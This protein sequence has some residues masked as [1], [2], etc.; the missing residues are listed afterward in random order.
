MADTPGEEPLAGVEQA[1]ERRNV[2][3]ESADR[4][5]HPKTRQQLRTLEPGQPAGRIETGHIRIESS[6]QNDPGA[7]NRDPERTSAPGSG[8]RSTS[9]PTALASI[10]MFSGVRQPPVVA[11]RRR[12]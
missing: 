4:R 2:A 6:M 3:A 11:S 1:F 7:I 9:R 10:A 5:H 12:W 8:E